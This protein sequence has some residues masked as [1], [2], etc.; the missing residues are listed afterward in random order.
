MFLS[1]VH[2]ANRNHLWSDLLTPFSKWPPFFLTDPYREG[3][4][5]MSVLHLSL[6]RFRLLE[7]LCYLT[8]TRL[9][10]ILLSTD[11]I[12]YILSRLK[13]SLFRFRWQCCKCLAQQKIVIIVSVST[14][15]M[16][17]IN[18]E[19]TMNDKLKWR[20]LCKELKVISTVYWAATSHADPYAVG[21][22]WTDHFHA[23]L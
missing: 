20:F 21:K 11:L 18:L 23:S 13:V 4:H 5:N 22:V 15:L 9:F 12:Q 2:A 14:S 1:L 8:L 6:A 10:R 17:S 7:F 19:C 3:R 16:F